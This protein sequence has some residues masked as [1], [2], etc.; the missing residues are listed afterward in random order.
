MLTVATALPFEARDF[1]ATLGGTQSALGRGWVLTGRVGATPAQLVVSGPGARR[2][3]AAADA[4]KT[5]PSVLISAGVAGAL[6]DE[7]RAGAVVVADSVCTLRSSARSTD[8]ALRAL[9]Q[10]ALSECGVPWRSDR[11]LGVDE[12]LASE[13]VKREAGRQSGAGIVQME[14]HVWAG[15]AAAWGVPFLSLRVVL[16]TVDRELPEA[17]MLFPWR[18]PSAA[19]AIRVLVRRPREIP[20]LLALGRAQA[21]ARRALAAALH[22]VVGELARDAAGRD[23]G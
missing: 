9:A 6:R 7:L 16:D 19:S 10:A 15:R 21:R 11:C 1:G 8:P 2:V 14:D 13:A 22:A 17:A 5:K 3:A 4:L 18:G 20:A 23:P 12:V